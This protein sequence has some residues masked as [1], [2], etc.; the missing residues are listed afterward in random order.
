MNKNLHVLIADD[1]AEALFALSTLLESRGWSVVAVVN[2]AAALQELERNTF[3][4]I[5]LDVQMPGITGIEVASTIKSDPVHR[6]TPVALL[7]ANTDLES[8]IAG[9]DAGADTYLTKP[10]RKDELIAR[11]HALVRTKSL[12]QELKTITKEN[13]AL[14]AL[15]RDRDGAHNIVGSSKKITEIFSLID[16]IKDSMLPVLITGETG[17]GKELIARALHEQSIRSQK[18]LVI[19][20]CAAFSESLLESELFGHVRGAFTGAIRDKEG[21]FEL[22]DGGTLFLD[23]VGE[24][25]LPLQAKLLRVIQEGT[26]TPVG[27]TSIKKVSVRVV[28]A[29]HRDLLRRAQEGAFREDLYYRLSVLTVHL[30]PLRERQEDIPAL[31]VHFL[32]RALARDGREAKRFSPEVVSAFSAYRWPGNIRELQNE[33]ERL[34]LLSGDDTVLTDEHLS[35]QIRAARGTTLHT[36]SQPESHGAPAEIKPLKDLLDAYEKEII[37]ASMARN[38]GNKS[39]VAEELQISRTSLIKKVQGY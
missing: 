19:Q 28:T 9:L 25:S 27:G 32:K 12:Y 2:G 8:V 1:D 3:D 36:K 11:V 34:A 26:F 15:V 35:P 20:N 30:P 24:M 22:A 21:L 38:E 18:P 7:T 29:T 37:V 10:Y 33:V 17:T 13:V 6:F 16:K 14:K 39:K 31:A 4:L 23:E 5:I